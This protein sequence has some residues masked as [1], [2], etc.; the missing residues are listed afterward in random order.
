MSQL[1]LYYYSYQGIIRVSY[2]ACMY[3]YVEDT[4][5]SL[6][7]ETTFLSHKQSTGGYQSW[8]KRAS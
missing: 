8:T 7:S 6:I 3:V 1:Q 5:A 4:Y 2:I